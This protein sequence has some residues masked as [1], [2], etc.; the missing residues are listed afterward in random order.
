MTLD[1]EGGLLLPAIRALAVAAMLSAFGTR[2]FAAYVMPRTAEKLLP[3]AARRIDRALRRLARLSFAVALLVLPVWLVAEGV[4]MAGATTWQAAWAAVPV[5]L[6]TTSFGHLVAV[7]FLVALAG[8]AAAGWPRSALVLGVLLVGLQAGHGH[9]AAMY[10]GPSL[11]LGADLLHLWSAGAWLGGLV[12]LLLVVVIAP[13]AAGAV[14]ARWFSP[15]GKLCLVILVVSAIGQGWVVIAS[16][17]GLIGTAY[18]WVALAKA[19]LLGVLTGFACVNRYGLCPALRGD[20]PAAA[21]R[22]LIG[23]IAVQTGVGVLTLGAAALLSALTPAMDIAQPVWPLPFRIGLDGLAMD[24]T[25]VWTVVAGGAG[26]AA[27]L[28]MAALAVFSRRLRWPAVTGAI[29]AAWL[30]LPPLTALLIEAYPTT[31]FTSPTGFSATAIAAGAAQY[32]VTCVACHGPEG[33][34]NGP[35]AKSLA[36]PPADLTAA[37]LLMHTDGDLFWWLG[38]GI[39]GTDDRTL[40]MPAFQDAFDDDMRWALIDFLHA[41]YDGAAMAATGSWQEPVRAPAFQASCADRSVSLADL[42]GR[43]VRLVIGDAPTAPGSAEV[44]TIATGHAS[45][46]ACIAGDPAVPE[47]YAI[48]AGIPA[49][50]LPETQFLIDGQGWLRGVQR[51]GAP[52]GWDDPKMLAGVIADMR[53]HPVAAVGMMGMKM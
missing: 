8:V 14:A 24:P 21:R 20:R 32:S 42:H 48:S 25:L 45:G 15:L 53:A 3:D 22:R 44:L 12:P 50:D 49:E 31:Y 52:V 19:A 17:A 33:R 16:V 41:R 40:V 13:P 26:V 38:H 39:T 29:V 5:V 1:P 37:H 4:D 9:A 51:P 2:A 10:D 11:L 7:Q 36:E 34:G 46:D 35:L 23:S 43:F 6:R 47:A 18:G 30:G 27:A 28:A